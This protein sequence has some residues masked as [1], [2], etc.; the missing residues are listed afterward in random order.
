M[1]QV[2]A[3]KAIKF[4]PYSR[5]T[6]ALFMAA[7]CF[8]E[9]YLDIMT[10]NKR[11]KRERARKAKERAAGAKEHLA[12]REAK[13]VRDIRRYGRKLT[14]RQFDA[15]CYSRMPLV[16]FTAE[17]VEWYSLFQNKLLGVVI[18]DVT[19]D[20]Y[21]FVILG[22]DSRRLFRWIDGGPD[23]YQTPVEAREA[24]AV[25]LNEK[26][27]GPIKDKYPQGDE[28][29]PVLDLFNPI[30]P[31]EQQHRNYKVLANEQR[32]EAARNLIT[33][34]ANSFIDNDG[35][36]EREFQSNNFH[37]RLWELYLHIYF[38]NAGL[39]IENNHAAP[40][41]ELV[42]F[43]DKVFVEA[44][45]VNPSENPE[46]PDLP[47]PETEA[48]IEESLNDFMPIKFGSPLYSK[49]QKKYWEQE[50]VKGHPLVLAIHDYHNDNA[51]TWSRTALSEYLYG[52]RTR[53][54][55][56][57]PVVTQ[58]S[59]HEWMGKK[60]PSGMFYQEGCENISAVLFSNQA[61]I[62]KYNRMGKIAGLGSADVKMIRKGYLYN[63]DPYAIYPIPFA[64]D[65]DDPDYEE[66][67]SDGLIMFHNPKATIPLDPEIFPDISH[68]FYSEQDGF[69]G[70]H[71]P[72]DV[73]GS[74][75]VV[76]T[77]HE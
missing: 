64:K 34:I 15:Y 51:M 38:H 16:R 62:P 6:L 46:R 41:F 37:S 18:R 56:G 48:A 27:S 55:K 53:I 66:S 21:G 58:I 7:L 22:R 32:Y 11:K 54:E 33:E 25:H 30:L 8:K 71:Q 3:N 57:T 35:H 10:S 26:Y 63:P 24:L 76:V 59:T 68:I 13:L 77:T 12:N 39:L 5:R 4:A 61:T 9:L 67:W 65:L 60:I 42:K 47:P 17:E 1:C 23:F 74:I 14:R 45:T 69:T 2:N 70:F 29:D 19:D 43:G 44:V 75:T 52:I 31:S 20:D 28:V 50:H 49:V 36:Y 72:Y 73:L 40:D